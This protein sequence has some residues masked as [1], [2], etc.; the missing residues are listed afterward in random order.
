MTLVSKPR[1]ICLLGT[2]ALHRPGS[3]LRYCDL[4]R[5]ALKACEW[6]GASVSVTS[7]GHMPVAL[8]H[9]P[10]NIA[11]WL[12]HAIIASRARHLRA[13]RRD[14][15]YHVLDGSYGYIVPLLQARQTVVTVHDLIPLLQCHGKLGARPYLPAQ[16]LIH[17][18]LVGIR[19]ADAVIAVSHHTAADL[20]KEGVRADRI[21][22]VHNAVSVPPP[23]IQL[24]ARACADGGPEEPFILHVGHNGFYKNRETVIRVA[25]A[26]NRQV[27]VALTLVGPPLSRAERRIVDQSGIG[28]RIKVCSGIPQV[29]LDHF[30]RHATVLLFPSLYE[31]FGWPPLEAM[32]RGCPVVSSNTASLSEVVNDAA[33]TA[34][35]LDV[36]T[37]TQHCLR[38]LREKALRCELIE[39]GHR[40]V[41]RFP[42]S[43]M[44][45]SLAQ[46]YATLLADS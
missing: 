10:G 20:A 18:S 23:G 6:N 24:D 12:Q 31:G 21:T 17:R 38:V 14:A 29:E 43:A 4:V 25:A 46:V 35:P 5:Q 19:M 42:P 13:H 40:N 27:P 9:L 39:K 16:W 34:S 15:I 37:L 22:V 32:A 45:Q 41:Q 44:G 7:L 36:D 2:H 26:V 11:V 8:Q 3:M 28:Q 30:Y 1:H 33:L